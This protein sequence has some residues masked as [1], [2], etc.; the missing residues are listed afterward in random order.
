D[1]VNRIS[2]DSAIAGTIRVI[3]QESQTM[4]L[5]SKPQALSCHL[6]PTAYCLLP[7]AYCLLP[8]AYCLLPIA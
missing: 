6:L 1:P 7:T 3:R 2:G 8:I 5:K 4:H